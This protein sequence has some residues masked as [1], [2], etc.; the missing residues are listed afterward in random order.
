MPNWCNNSEIIV[1]P[2]DEIKVLYNKLVEWTSKEFIKTD[3][4]EHWIGNI[5]IGAGFDHYD[6]ECRG[7]I[8][9]YFTY[10]PLDDKEATIQFSSITAWSPVTDTWYKILDRHAPDSD[11]YYCSEEPGSCIFETN[12]IY[13]RFFDEHYIIFP[14][15][16]NPDKCPEIFKNIDTNC[17]LTDDEFKNFLDEVIQYFPEIKADSIS[18]MVEKFNDKFNVDPHENGYRIFIHEID[19]IG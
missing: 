3:F 17:Y 14:C 9:D 11:Y 12:D 7:W 10:Q 5:V 15:I 1:G 13:S 16:N 18:A 2:I 8:E 4:G 19:F 6:L